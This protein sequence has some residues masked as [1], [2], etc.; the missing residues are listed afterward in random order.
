MSVSLRWSGA[1]AA[2][3]F[4]VSAPLAD[5]QQPSADASR[6][7]VMP[8]GG[9]P[10]AG[11][12]IG[13]F[14]A[15]GQAQP[16]YY[17]YNPV[18]PGGYGAGQG[19]A[20]AS[21]RAFDPYA[22]ST[23][24]GY[25]PY[26]AGSGTMS[27]SSPYGLSTSPYASQ[28]SIP[29]ILPYGPYSYG[30]GLIGAGPGVGYGSAL[31]GLASYTQAAGRYWIDIQQA[32]LMREQVHQTQIETARRRIQFEQWYESVRPT[33][34]KMLENERRSE[35]E[36]ARRDANDGE[37]TSGRALNALLGSIRGAGKVSNPPNIPVDAALL[38]QVNLSGGSSSGNVGML[39]DG[40]KLSWPDGLMD[41]SYDEA[42]KR[43][44]RNLRNA[45]DMAK[46]G[47]PITPALLK[48]IRADYNAI[49]NKLSEGGQDDVS[50]Q[51]YM[52][53]RR[54]LTQLNASINALRDP[55]VSKYFN[56]TWDAKG[57]TV[58]ELV[59]HMTREGLTFAPAAPGQEAAY[60]ALYPAL[61]AYEAGLQVAQR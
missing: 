21:P 56:K 26:M 41:P 31:Q 15:A 18:P 27:A 60:R 32:R 47:D 57:N 55:N 24:P 44:T 25:N 12:S 16:N 17:G 23:A 10:A 40:V 59:D 43:L 45:V 13:G 30:E 34:G 20:T 6:P 61:R 5:A 1:L 28:S 11:P 36:R 50:A 2:A 4:A 37:V 58:A 54:F 51:Q 52:E 29:P 39:K 8:A 19:P 42:R 46:E 35:V 9:A 48:D 33:A 38:R 22:L 53:A 7:Q 49:N 3:V 14:G